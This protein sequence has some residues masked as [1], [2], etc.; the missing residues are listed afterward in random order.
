MLG[1]AIVPNREFR[2]QQTDHDITPFGYHIFILLSTF[3]SLYWRIICRFW[4]F[5]YRTEHAVLF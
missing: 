4:Q 1:T 2:L 3:L 5:L